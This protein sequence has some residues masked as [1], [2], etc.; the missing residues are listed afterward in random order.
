MVKESELHLVFRLESGSINVYSAGFW[1]TGWILDV[2]SLEAF[3]V[4]SDTGFECFRYSGVFTNQ[5]VV[6]S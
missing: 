4:G 6:Y 1:V 3:T 2:G 5:P